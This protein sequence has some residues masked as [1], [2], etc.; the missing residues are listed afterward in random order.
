MA[1]TVRY[2]GDPPPSAELVIIGG[3]IVGAATAFHASRAGLRPVLIERRAALCTLTTP[4]S[5]GAYRLQFDNREE[6]ELV[7]ESVAL[8]LDFAVV[9]EQ[10]EYDL[11]IRRQGYLWLTTSEARAAE[12]RALVALQHEW[13][14]DDIEVLDGDEVRARWPYVADDVLQARFR[15]DD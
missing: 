2:T 12:Q 8:F 11:R 7:R 14:Q 15:A 9:T 3:G 10:R 5:T 6:L 1:E 4:A 13:G